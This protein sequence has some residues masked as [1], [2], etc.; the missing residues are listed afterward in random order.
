MKINDFEI[1]AMALLA[2]LVGILYLVAGIKDADFWSKFRG[3]VL[4][5]SSIGLY[6]YYKRNR[7][8]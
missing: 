2:F 8:C 7:K 5:A 3:G 4:L 1:L 6:I